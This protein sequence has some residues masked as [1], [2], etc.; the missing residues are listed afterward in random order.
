MSQKYFFFDEIQQT[1][2]QESYIFIDI[3]FCLCFC[4]LILGRQLNLD[5]KSNQFN[6]IADHDAS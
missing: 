2:V 1:P 3:L 5:P 4:R 6:K